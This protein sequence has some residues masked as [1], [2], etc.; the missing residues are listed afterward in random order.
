MLHLNFTIKELCEMFE[1]S[2]KNGHL[3]FFPSS[4]HIICKDE[5]DFEVSLCPGLKH[6]P[7]DSSAGNPFLPPDPN[8]IITSDERHVLLFNK[9]CVERCHLLLITKAFERQDEMFSLETFGTVFEVLKYLNSVAIPNSNFKESMKW[10]AFYNSDKIA[11]AS[12]PHRHFQ[13]I[14]LSKDLP[15]TDPFLVQAESPSA[16]FASLKQRILSS[17]Y[18]L[19]LA[20]PGTCLLIAR[21]AE[22][23]TDDLSANAL[24]FAGRILV[25]SEAQ[26]DALR[27]VDSVLN[28][29]LYY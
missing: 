20:D 16:L 25:R 12:Q 21:K 5:I 10:I 11:G 23:I 7:R 24:V 8:L 17:S 1:V 22:H 9:Y 27:M 15:I 28:P 3:Y 18:N 19:I 2:L 14:P 29:L 4:R 6:K 13:F 26:L